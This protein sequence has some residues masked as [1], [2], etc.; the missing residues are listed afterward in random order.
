MLGAVGKN[1]LRRKLF[2]L[3]MLLVALGAGA[4][5]WRHYQWTA[6]KTL[7]AQDHYSEAQTHVARCLWLWGQDPRAML[8]AAR[9]ARFQGK[10]QEAADRLTQA[11]ELRGGADEQ[12]QLEWTLL[13]VQ[14]GELPERQTGLQACLAEGHPESALILKTL[15]ISA[16]RSLH[17]H[18]AKQYLE[19]WE[20]LDPRNPTLYEWRG[21]VLE[22]LD[23]RDDALAAYKKCLELDPDRAKP[24]LRLAEMLLD[25]V[26]PRE[27]AQY[28]PRLS[29]AN[30]DD[31]EVLLVQARYHDI[32]GELGPARALSDRLLAQDP[33]HLQA[34]V[35]RA[36]IEL[37]ENAPTLAEGYLRRALA[38]RPFDYSANYA[39]LRCLT[40]LGKTDEAAAQTAKVDAIQREQRRLKELIVERLEITR[41]RAEVMH[42]I[43]ATLFRIG[44]DVRALDWLYRTLELDPDH[45][46]THRLL[47]DYYEKLGDRDKADQHRQR[48]K[49]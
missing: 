42:E 26:Q 36:N 47:V 39:F 37:K 25:M 16:M 15:A 48:L 41:A 28:L 44:E 49:S 7:F 18:A 9:I 33:N 22:R 13:R 27:A 40:L 4:A 12:L 14:R 29:R 35:L 43:G 21:W 2:W 38:V 10:Y 45:Q 20:Q 3:L 8:L 23:G 31:P 11:R 1:L 34:N 5:A 46:A 32:L 24:Q 17:F 6:A 19:E 30:P